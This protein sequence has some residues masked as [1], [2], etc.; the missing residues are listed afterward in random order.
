MKRSQA[1]VMERRLRGG[2][3]RRQTMSAR[4]SHSPRSLLTSLGATIAAGGRLGDRH[5]RDRLEG[6]GRGPH[7]R[8]GVRRPLR[9]SGDAALCSSPR[10]K[11]CAATGCVKLDGE[12]GQSDG[13]YVASL[14]LP[15]EGNWALTVDSRYCETKMKAL[16]LKASLAR[17]RRAE[18]WRGGQGV[19]RPAASGRRPGLRPGPV[20][21]RPGRGVFR[22]GVDLARGWG[23]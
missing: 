11:R 7:V 22:F 5:H 18:R 21:Y 12:G 13:R 10:S 16:T 9:L 2:H 6:S 15:T 14:T 20:E 3:E 4:T 23:G 17:T 1:P 8:C 19:A